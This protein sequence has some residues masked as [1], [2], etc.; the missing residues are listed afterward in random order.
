MAEEE[1]LTETAVEPAA[2]ATPTP[3][4]AAQSE[5]AF[6]A[7]NRTLALRRQKQKVA[8]L[9]GGQ[10]RLSAP[11]MHARYTMTA[12]AEVLGNIEASLTDDWKREHIGWRYQWPIRQ[13]NQTASFIRA[14]LFVPVPFEAIDE[15][16]PM[17]AIAD[18]VTTG[19]RW[20]IW[21]SHLLVAVPPDRWDYLVQQ[22]EDFAVARTVNSADE[23]VDRLE[24]MFGSGGYHAEVRP[25]TDKRWNTTGD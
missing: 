21:K 5:N 6:L 10:R 24:Q 18:I 17:A 11:Y 25:F 3:T 16:N 9:P 19:G 23:T 7:K 15:S 12:D 20:V 4:T 8:I 13:D 1:K 14:G 2:T 22:Y